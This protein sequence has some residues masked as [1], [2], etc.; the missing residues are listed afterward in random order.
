LRKLLVFGLALFLV[1][2]G[3][4]FVGA[5]GQGNVSTGG[6]IFIGPFPIAFGS[7]PAGWELALV[8]VAIGGVM[9]ALVL[10][11]GWRFAKVS[12]GG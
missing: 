1:G 11:W 7:G 6:V 10:L 3:L 5:A 4:L 2:F 12:E 8:S 9:L